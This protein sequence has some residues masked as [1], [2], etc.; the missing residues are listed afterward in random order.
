M[1]DYG[2]KVVLLCLIFCIILFIND[3]I[4]KNKVKSR[5]KKIVVGGLGSVV[6]IPLIAVILY[7]IFLYRGVNKVFNKAIKRLK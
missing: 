1:A 5:S 6:F 7:I 4:K 3:T 2:I